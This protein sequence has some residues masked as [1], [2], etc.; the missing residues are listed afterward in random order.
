MKSQIYRISKNKEKT[1]NKAREHNSK[2]KQKIKDSTPCNVL[3]ISLCTA[4]A[5][6]VKAFLFAG[7]YQEKRRKKGGGGGGDH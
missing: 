1:W 7:N 5:V 6:C 3:F 2:M 4:G